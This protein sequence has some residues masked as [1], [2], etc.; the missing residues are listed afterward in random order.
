MS[1]ANE[2]TW[3]RALRILLGLLML[4]AGWSG[5][6]TGVWGVALK[7]F[8]WVP[9]VTGLLGWCPFYAILGVST[10]KTGPAAKEP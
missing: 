10:R 8:A 7:I 1:F 2:A 5:L 3:D 9:L 6:V 4:Y